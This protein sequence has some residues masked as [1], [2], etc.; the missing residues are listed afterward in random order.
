MGSV[1]LYGNVVIGKLSTF[2]GPGTVIA[3]AKSKILIGNYCSIA[4]GVKM[5]S[6]NHK[7]NRIT[8]YYILR[9]VC[10]L[11]GGKDTYTKGDIVLEDD[12]WIGTNSVILSGVKIG[13][14]SI[15]GAGSVVTSDIPS[16]SIVTG[17]PGKV[18]KSRFSNSTIKILEN[19]KWW[20][21]EIDL[22]KENFDLFT[23]TEEEIVSNQKRLEKI[24]SK[25]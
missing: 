5:Y 19:S 11:K 23:M 24:S 22:I 18:I 2:N 7:Y 8:T 25:Y 9:N 6:A 15:I 3:G 14:G 12:V 20:E 13:R 16:Y 1:N 17:N 21:W 10:N 4:P